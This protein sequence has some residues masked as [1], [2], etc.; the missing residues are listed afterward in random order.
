M[1]HFK[2][3]LTELETARDQALDR[4]EFLN[5]EIE[6]ITRILNK[7]KHAVPHE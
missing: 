6:R 7:E 2:K 5:R 1:S 4:V 3:I